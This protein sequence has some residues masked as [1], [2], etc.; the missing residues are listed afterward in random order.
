MIITGLLKLITSFE[1]K[2]IGF[3]K[4]LFRPAHN[5]INKAY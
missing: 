5:N 1:M 2:L 3:M 4:C